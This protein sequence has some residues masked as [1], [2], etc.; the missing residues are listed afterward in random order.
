MAKRRAIVLPP[1]SSNL[2][3]PT[4]TPSMEPS[5]H[6]GSSFSLNDRDFAPLH[7]ASFIGD[8]EW[9]RMEAAMGAT[10]AG[11]ANAR[12]ST[13]VVAIA[14]GRGREVGIAAMDVVNVREL[15][16]S[17]VTD[18]Q[19]F[20]QTLALLETYAPAEVL[21]A[22]THVDRVLSRK[23]VQL[24]EP[25]GVSIVRVARRYY[26]DTLGF[27][28]VERLAIR[29][30]EPDMTHAFLPLSCAAALLK[31]VEHVQSV[32][33]APRALVV[34][35]QDV[36]GRVSLDF[37]TVRNLELI[38]NARTGSQRQSL[39]GVVD[40]TKTAVGARL[41]RATLLCPSNDLSTVNARL[42]AV[43][44]LLHDETR[45]AEAQAA[46]ARCLDLDLIASQLVQ[47]PKTFTPRTARQALRAVI[48]LRH[49]LALLPELAAPLE[50]TTS[51]LLA[52]VHD[53]LTSPAGPAMRAAIDDMVRPQAPSE[54]TPGVVLLTTLSRPQISEGTA[55][56][57][58]A[59]PMRQYECFAVRP[60]VDGLLDVARKTYLQSLND[61]HA[62]V[63]ELRGRLGMPA[64]QLRYTETRG[65][66]LFLPGRPATL[67]DELCQATQMKQGIACSTDE[68]LSLNE[69]NREALTRVYVLTNEA[70]QGLLGRLRDGLAELYKIIEAVAL[71]DMLQGFAVVAQSSSGYVRPSL[72]AGGALVLRQARHPAVERLQQQRAFV[73]N[74]AFLGPL[75]SFV[76]VTG[77]NC[78]GKSTFLKQVAIVTILALAGCY[79]PADFACVRL[80]DRIFTRIGTSDNMEQ[81]AST[82]VCEMR[83]SAYILEHC[84]ERSLVI[85]D[86]LGRGQ[87]L[88]RATAAAFC[89]DWQCSWTCK[90]AA[91][92]S[93]TGFRWRGPSRSSSSRA[94]APPCLPRTSI[95]CPASSPCILERA[96]CTSTRVAWREQPRPHTSSKTASCQP[97]RSTASKWRPNWACLPAWL[98][99]R[100]AF[101][102]T[103]RSV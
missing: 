9:T 65:F 80:V 76:I 85:I 82:F 26:S 75:S 13:F 6:S 11:A 52:A 7:E 17:Q 79:V 102:A 44:E 22:A 59:L 57:K 12:S 97:R 45:L 19:S 101:V 98:T 84:T 5:A 73:P 56:S 74:D 60:G 93:K 54:R 37:E 46:L 72:T 32:R 86:E 48:A 27:G 50:A 42:D 14:E 16:L 88:L 25:R 68:L 39:F 29:G 100:G 15:L 41:L 89:L 70:L 87:V 4:P 34:R 3:H 31:Y 66:H 58:S 24:L 103:S 78:S 90:R 35:W 92:R 94:S 36:R 91:P 69:R 99:A 55:W 67:P 28:L 18:S 81:N 96:S 30:V 20:A 61:I 1:Q 62:L 63:D 21:V 49:C 51:H 71:L 40:R 95:T 47:V 23:V 2:S 33:L 38:T 77:C 8:S 43:D 53:V 10:G 64:L 83:E